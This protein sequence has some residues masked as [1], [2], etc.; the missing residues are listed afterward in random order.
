M[1]VGQV[2]VGDGLASCE[3]PLAAGYDAGLYDLDGVL[4]LATEPIPHAAASLASAT[5]LG[6]RPAYVTNNASR[7][8]AVVAALLASVGVSAVE[9][10][11]VTSAQASV[12]LLHEQ[13]DPGSEVLVIGS[14]DLAAAV[15]DGGYA[16]VR[17]AGPGVRAV[18][19]GLSFDVGW[20]QLA[21]AAVAI[22]A[23]ALW[24][25]ANTDTTFPSPRGPLPGCGALVAALVT[26]TGRE[27]VVAG[28]PGPALHAEAVE[29]VSAR[30]PLV[31]GDRL[32]TDVLGAVGAGAD[33]LLVL[34]GVCTLEALLAAPAGSRPA[35]VAADLR[36]LLEAHPPVELVDGGAR[37]GTA[38]AAYDGKVSEGAGVPEL[39]A[40]CAAA[41]ARAD[42][43]S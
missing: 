28:K 4:Y 32:D 39:R 41:W 15:A 34:T 33:S 6:L 19:Q 37:C 14:D 13:V 18:V 10:D 12:R 23:G 42:Q 31:I 9:H 20:L 25:A 36:G 16:P 8:P 3:G 29:R 40:A 38:F 35:F 2:L 22:R 21:E 43:M 1:P 26:A 17:E 5:E 30:R 27:P 7:S 24:V 11:V